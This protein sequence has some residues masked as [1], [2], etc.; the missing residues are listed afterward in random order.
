MACSPKTRVVSSARALIITGEVVVH[1]DAPSQWI[2]GIG[3]APVVVIAGDR[4]VGA[5]VGRVAAV[6]RTGILVIARHRGKLAVE[7]W[8]ARVLR[9]KIVVKTRF[10]GVDTTN[11][12]VT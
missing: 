8:V 6:H 11:R 9:A 5:A 12:R 3:S 7:L 1:K 10:R 4:A 2:T